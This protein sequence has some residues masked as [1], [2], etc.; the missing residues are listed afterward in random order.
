MAKYQYFTLEKFVPVETESIQALN[1]L[2]EQ[3]YDVVYFCHE[4]NWILL[5]REIR[6]G[7]AGRTVTFKQA[8][9]VGGMG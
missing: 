4:W 7:S 1:E 5:K 2:G 6:T 9:N 3:G 8:E